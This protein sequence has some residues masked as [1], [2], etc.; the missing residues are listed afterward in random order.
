VQVHPVAIPFVQ[1]AAAATR[2]PAL[3]LHSRRTAGPRRAMSTSS[4]ERAQTAHIIARAPSIALPHAHSAPLPPRTLDTAAWLREKFPRLPVSAEID[5][6]YSCALVRPLLIQGRLY[7][8]GDALLFYAKIFGRVTKEYIPLRE[9]ERVRKRRSGFVANAVKITFLDDSVPGVV[10]GSLTRRERACALINAKVQG[11]RAAQAEDAASGSGSESGSVGSGNFEKIAARDDVFRTKNVSASTARTTAWLPSRSRM[12][13]R[14]VASGT[15][16]IGEDRD[17]RDRHIFPEDVAFDTED[18]YLDEN[19][20]NDGD[21]S[22]DE[23]DDDDDDSENDDNE[24]DAT[25][26]EATVPCELSFPECSGVFS[27]VAASTADLT[28]RENDVDGITPVPTVNSSSPDQDNHAAIPPLVKATIAEPGVPELIA[29]AKP[30]K[31]SSSA[32]EQPQSLWSTSDDPFDSIAGREYARRVEQARTE[33]SAPVQRAFELL[34]ASDWLRQVNVTNGNTDVEITPWE[35][36]AD[37][38]FMMRML[39]FS[40]ALGYRI[41]PKVTRVV[42]THKYSFTSAGGVVVETSGHNVDVPFGDNFRVE[43]YIELTPIAAPDASAIPAFSGAASAAVSSSTSSSIRTLM[44]VSVAVYFAK[45]SMLRST[46]ESGTL[47]ETKATFTRMV[48]LA[49]L[50]V[51]EANAEAAAI[52]VPPQAPARTLSALQNRA[53]KIELASTQT[54][55]PKKKQH[56]DL[57]AGV[58]VAIPA[59]TV[60]ATS[61]RANSAGST[62]SKTRRRTPTSDGA[63]AVAVNGANVPVDSCTSSL[64]SAF[65]SS[66]GGINDT[67]K[68]F[69]STKSR[70]RKSASTAADQDSSQAIIGKAIAADVTTIGTAPSTTV[71]TRPQREIHLMRLVG[72]VALVAIAVLLLLCVKML[73]RLQ[74]DMQRL[75]RLALMRLGERAGSGTCV[76]DA[77]S[78]AASA[79]DGAASA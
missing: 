13:A 73:V 65:T 52:A 79:A 55:I 8:T 29:Y 26:E 57:T 48:D 72:L 34:V 70:G 1:P 35:R 15:D 28:E 16:T 21:E 9:V 42:E 61:S 71:V 31:Q 23:D 47:A 62:R 20:E 68:R 43:S 12:R 11:I 32:F 58:A 64:T 46:I 24:F 7:V 22:D 41:G 5:A 56:S 40:R 60:H 59:V 25:S 74:A 69:S 63:T 67:C 2:T 54:N 17:D 76:S 44:V 53:S 75:E 33:L 51:D 19:D 78:T 4:I 6:S 39:T 18:G 27:S 66:H 14:R 38:G 77:G 49:A 3:P 50:H 45:S 36:C 30:E 10:F 37:D